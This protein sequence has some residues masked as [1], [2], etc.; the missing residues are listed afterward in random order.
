MYLFHL[1]EDRESEWL[2]CH[3]SAVTC[4]CVCP[5]VLVWAYVYVFMCMRTY[6]CTVCACVWR[7]VD[8]SYH[9]DS[10]FTEAGLSRAQYSPTHQLDSLSCGSLIFTS[11]KLGL[12]LVHHTLQASVLVLE[13]QT[14]VLILVAGKLWGEGEEGG[15]GERREGGTGGRGEGRGWEETSFLLGLME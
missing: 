6:L 7:G 1:P 13:N 4:V 8:I 14:L 12:Q 3:L 15:G 9:Y 11:A 5:C 10:L 2:A